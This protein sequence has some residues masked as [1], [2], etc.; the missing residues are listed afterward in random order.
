MQIVFIDRSKNYSEHIKEYVHRHFLFALSRF[1]SKI[2]KVCITLEDENSRKDGKYKKCNV[3]IKL[4]KLSDIIFSQIDSS[5]EASIAK[6]AERCGRTV[7]R[8][9]ELINKPLINRKDNN[10][11]TN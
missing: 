8:R 11:S 2:N 3:T 1:D 6:A 9:I 7:A 4:N 5:V 10:D